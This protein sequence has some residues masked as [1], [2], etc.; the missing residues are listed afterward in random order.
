ME[1]R[2]FELENP[3]LVSQSRVVEI[4]KDFFEVSKTAQFE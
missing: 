1:S 2:V 3:M 4:E